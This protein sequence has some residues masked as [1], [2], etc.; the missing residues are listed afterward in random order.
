M[1]TYTNSTNIF[2][3][4]P[5]DSPANT[6]IKA[7]HS[8]Y[9]KQD[10]TSSAPASSKHHWSTSVPPSLSRK[11]RQIL[12]SAGINFNIFTRPKMLPKR[13]VQ[14]GNKKSQLNLE[15]DIRVYSNSTNNKQLDK[16][17]GRNMETSRKVNGIY[18]MEK[19]NIFAVLK[20]QMSCSFVEAS[21]PIQLFKDEDRNRLNSLYTGSR[22]LSVI[23]SPAPLQLRDESSNSSKKMNCPGNGSNTASENRRY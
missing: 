10:K 5:S 15:S 17:K 4:K 9:Q 18:T 2:E 7:R 3:K 6:I 12:A 22:G 11:D 23:S 21:P 8:K 13:N 19:T 14:M 1:R 16:D 20:K